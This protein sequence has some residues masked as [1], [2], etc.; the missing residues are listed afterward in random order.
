[1]NKTTLRQIINLNPVLNAG[2]DSVGTDKDTI[3]NFINGFY[4]E[5]FAKYQDKKI[6]LL[7][8]GINAG[9][10][11]FLWSKYFQNGNIYGIEVNDKIQPYFKGLPNIRYIFSDA[12]NENTIKYLPQFDIIID[13]GPHS[14]ESQKYCVSN[15][16]NKLN[17]GG[18]MIIED[19]QSPH[20]IDILQSCVPKDSNLKS[21]HADLRATRGRYDDLLFIVE[22][23][24][25][26]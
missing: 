4:E 14:L 1:M 26:C 6:N 11:L 10:S 2:D 25:I 13:D 7:E 23:S 17:D 20:H 18:I 16:I 9:G 24:N 15:Y 12:Y 22:K 19:I 5:N 21:Y 8:I 3:H